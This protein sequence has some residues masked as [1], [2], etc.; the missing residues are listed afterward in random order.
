MANISL[1]R[2]LQALTLASIAILAALIAL[3]LGFFVLH[4]AQVLRYP[5]PLDYG[6]G[7]LLAQIEQLRHGVSLRDLYGPLDAPPYLVVNYPPVYLLVTWAASSLTGNVLLA[8][9]L[10]SLAAALACVG[11]LAVIMSDGRRRTKDESSTFLLSSFVFRLSS[12][13]LLALPIVREWAVLMRVDL[14]GVAL[15]L[16]ALVVLQRGQN[17]LPPSHQ[18]TKNLASNLSRQRVQL[19]IAAA[20]LCASLFTKPSLAAAPCAALVFLLLRDWR[21]ALELVGW[22]ALF[23]GT[24]LIMLVPGTHVLDHVVLAN[25]NA[26]QADL[27]AGFWRGQLAI[28]WGLFAAGAFGAALLVRRRAATGWASVALPITYT[29]VGAIGAIG[30]GKVGA[31]LNYFLELYVGLIWLVGAGGWGLGAGGQADEKTGRQEDEK[32]RRQEDEKISFPSSRLPVFPSS[33]LPIFPSSHLP[34]F[35]SSHLP[36]SPSSRLPIFLSSLLLLTATALISYYPTWSETTTKLA[37]LVELNPPRFV[38]GRRGVWQ[39][40]RR[41]RQILAVYARTNTALV[42]EV[43]AAGEP[44]LTDIPAVAAQAGQ[45]A[46]LQAFEHGQMLRMWDQRSLRLDLANGTIPLAVIEYL[47]NWLTPEVIALVKHRY[48]QEGSRGDYDLY[49]PVDPGPLVTGKPIDLLGMRLNGYHLLAQPFHAGETVPLTLVWAHIVESQLPTTQPITVTVT[50]TDAAQRTVL[51]DTQPLFYGALRPDEL[52]AATAQHMQP[53]RLPATLE[54]GQYALHVALRWGFAASPAQQLATLTVA[55]QDGAF[56]PNSWLDDGRTEYIPAAILSAWQQLGGE[57]RFGKP[58]TP[59]VPFVGFVQQ[60]F[61][62]GCVRGEDERRKTKDESPQSLPSSVVH[63]LSSVGSWLAAG[64]IGAKKALPSSTVHRLSSVG[65]WLAAGDIGAN[66]AFA[67]PAISPGF[68]ACYAS[69]GGAA[70]LGAAVTNEFR[71]GERLVQY[72]EF[73][74]LER[75]AAGGACSLGA[76]GVDVLRLQAGVPYRWP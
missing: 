30:V 74:R 5:F 50:L 48:A 70:S 59:A 52:G 55:A 12:C 67:Q 58:L 56:M 40:L 42:A 49:R 57:P 16:W 45:V 61:E 66:G 38:V 46:R 69:F 60:C 25:V 21:R 65:S 75:P 53:L 73:A 20:L 39:D 41:E 36:I 14:L 10:V 9:R 22:L 23:G 17:V 24:A 11:A 8:G 13:T 51:T 47:G 37:G 3:N 54:P 71:S 63:R 62:R 18:A 76:V 72:T 1:W 43:Q 27:A 33:H 4:A 68:A 44:I 19:I 2:T 35:P 7:P 28:H 64:D 15:G 32:I 26:W 31:Y 29:L 34:I 6:E